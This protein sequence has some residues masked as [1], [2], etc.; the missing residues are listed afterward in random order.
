MA[1]WK[2]GGL[3][4][5]PDERDYKFAALGGAT[6]TI[7][8]YKNDAPY[9]IK[10]QGNSSMC[11]AFSGAEYR[12]SRE[13]HQN[14]R[15]EDLSRAFI[16]GSDDYTGEGM[17]SRDLAKILTNGTCYEKFWER[18]GNKMQ[19]KA[20]HDKF[21]PT[22]TDEIHELRGDSYYFCESWTEVLNAIRAT[23]GCILMVA[24][25]PNWYTCPSTGIVGKNTGD[26]QG[27]HFVFARDYEQKENG[28]YRIRFQNSWGEDW[29]DKGMGYFDTDVNEFQDAFAVVDDVNEVKAKMKFSDVNDSDWFAQYVEQ[30]SDAG[31][32]TGF[33]DGT[34]KPDAT[35]TRAQIA[36][37]A[38]RIKALIE[39]ELRTNGYSV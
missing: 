11:G 20:L 15:V 1:E 34:F 30:A 18:T 35:V 33:E 39:A 4:S 7:E 22:L 17:Y 29:G 9:V 28:A 32:M 23:D 10:N 25:Y 5:P 8:P 36:V 26:L 2:L 6:A 16:Y 13:W 24:V 12:H 27:Y 31:L 37:I 21:A 14:A 19:C 3:I 38:M